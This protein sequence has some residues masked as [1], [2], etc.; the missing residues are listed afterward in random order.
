MDRSRDYVVQRLVLFNPH[1]DMDFC[2]QTTEQ[3]LGLVGT[4]RLVLE[5]CRPDDGCSCDEPHV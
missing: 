1:S 4:A 5:L 3:V 2:L